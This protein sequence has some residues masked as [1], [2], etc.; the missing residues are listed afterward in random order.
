MDALWLDAEAVEWQA[1]ARRFVEEELYPAEEQIAE[2]G[3][4][5]ADEVRE[6][7]LRARADGFS[8]YN[9]PS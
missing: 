4:V 7:R 8:H 1:R 5:D 9:L 2:R 6:L 3:T